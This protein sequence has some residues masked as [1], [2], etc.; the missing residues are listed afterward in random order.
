MRM[1]ADKTVVKRHNAKHIVCVILLRIATSKRSFWEIRAY[2]AHILAH[3]VRI[4][5]Y[6][7]DNILKTLRS[8]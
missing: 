1:T 3:T 6:N 7:I 8:N 4:Y 2:G 5:L